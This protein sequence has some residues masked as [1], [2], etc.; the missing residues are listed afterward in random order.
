M[1]IALITISS[2]RPSIH[3]YLRILL[4]GG[5]CCSSPCVLYSFFWFQKNVF[6]DNYDFLEFQY[7]LKKEEDDAEEETRRLVG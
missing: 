2:I 6:K 5:N 4:P 3:R 1:E 7:F